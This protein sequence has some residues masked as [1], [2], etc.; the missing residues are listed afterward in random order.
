MSTTKHQKQRR[1][2][3]NYKR[4]F[5]LEMTEDQIDKLVDATGSTSI[6]LAKALQKALNLTIEEL[7]KNRI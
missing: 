5:K 2:D 6:D 1:K 3:K 4:I 7:A